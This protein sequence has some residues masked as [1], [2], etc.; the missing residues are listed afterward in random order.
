MART[1]PIHDRIQN[2]YNSNENNQNASTNVNCSGTGNFWVIPEE[3]QII[4]YVTILGETKF[5]EAGGFPF[6]KFF[7]RKN[8]QIIDKR[9]QIINLPEITDFKTQNGVS[10][11]VDLFVQYTITDVRKYIANQLNLKEKLAE[12]IKAIMQQ[13]FR[14]QE[15]KDISKASISI[16]EIG[17]DKF[18][19]L[20]IQYG[21]RFTQFGATKLKLPEIDDDRTKRV[22]MRTISN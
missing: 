6:G 15:S 10:V 8:I 2:H 19:S 17:R 9:D 21:I 16:D 4:K 1:N 5:K 22:E 20:E 18:K 3:Y 12:N 14:N 11:A 7:W 13:Y